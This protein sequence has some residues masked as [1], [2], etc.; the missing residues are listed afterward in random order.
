MTTQR[1]KKNLYSGLLYS[2]LIATSLLLQ[3][4]VSPQQAS[5]TKK[6]A[7]SWALRGKIGMLYP[8]ANCTGND[9]RLRSDQGGIQWQQEKQHYTIVLNDPFG[10][11]VLQLTG[12][13]QQ[14]QATAPGKS[15]V[16]AAPD[17]F[18][19]LLTKQ[20]TQQ[21]LL[22]GLTP[23]DLTYWVTGRPNPDY[24]AKKSAHHFEQKGFTISASQWRRTPVGNLPSLVALSKGQVKLRIVIK[25]WSKI[26]QH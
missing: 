7:N 12:D 16:A 3:A 1:T 21:N 9:C 10:R 5:V 17:G 14:V 20:K 13:N 19:R 15:A 25:E 23:K 2:S 11:E 4:C 8:E 22:A 18:A 6:I 26:A 24:A